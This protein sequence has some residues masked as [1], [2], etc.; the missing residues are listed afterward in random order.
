MEAKEEE[1]PTPTDATME[2]IMDHTLRLSP[3]FVCLGEIRSNKEFKQ[4]MK[5]MQAGHPIN[6]TF[7]AES[8][9]GAV[10][11]FLTAYLATSGNEPSHLALRT[12][13]GLVNLIIVQKIMR[14]GKRRIIQISEVV[15]VDPND[16]EKPLI[17]DL[18]IFDI[19]KDPELNP[20]GT[21]KEIHGTHKRVGKLSDRLV[22][23]F[24]LEGV[25]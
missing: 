18:Y 19:D 4:A 14:D 9:E 10:Q 25:A 12:L 7:H 1:N 22:R 24:N 15:G 17:N 3:T 8:S 21:V 11:R 2:N 5:I 16:Q 13:T 6:T 20:D 23:K